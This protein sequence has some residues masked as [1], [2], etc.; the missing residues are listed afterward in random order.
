M[1]VIETIIDRLAKLLMLIGGIAL[2]LMMTH[3]F[4]DV[5][6]KNLFNAPVPITLEMASA[7]YMVAVVFLPMAMVER[8]NGHI[9]VELLYSALPR[10]GRRLLELIGNLL[11]FIFFALMTWRTWLTAVKKFEDSEFLMGE[12]S[13]IIWPSRFLVPIG[14]GLITVLLILKTIRSVT[15]LINPDHP[16]NAAAD[17]VSD[18][19]KRGLD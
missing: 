11:G 9:N 2:V 4:A 14:I 17:A 1:T 8:N 18:P 12:Y 7:Y 6:G 10:A 5:L 15:A 3:V 16:L 19:L 13:V